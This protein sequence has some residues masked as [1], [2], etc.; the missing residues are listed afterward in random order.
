MGGGSDLFVDLDGANV[1]FHHWHPVPVT[2]N[3]NR[4]AGQAE[5]GGVWEW[6]SSILARHEGFEA[7]PTYPGYT[8]TS[9]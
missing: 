6:T 8:G 9:C 5:M 3:G 2:A 7:M 1:G 4:L